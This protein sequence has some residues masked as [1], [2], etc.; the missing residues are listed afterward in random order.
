[1]ANSYISQHPG[2]WIQGMKL[3]LGQG[4]STRMYGR[5]YTGAQVCGSCLPEVSCTQNC[6]IFLADLN[7]ENA[8]SGTPSS[9][10]GKSGASTPSASLIQP[11]IPSG[12]VSTD[13]AETIIADQCITFDS[14]AIL[15]KRNKKI[16]VDPQ[17]DK[18][19]QALTA[20]MG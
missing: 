7:R 1:M 4:D 12:H 20:S 13:L 2:S 16:P 17:S 9:I 15:S 8:L 14:V 11:H 19:I 6:D 18:I 5:A 10:R 3:S